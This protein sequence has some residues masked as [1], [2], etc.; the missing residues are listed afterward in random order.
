MPGN[1]LREAILC[2]HG[3][4]KKTQP[5]SPGVL[6]NLGATK[7]KKKKRCRWVSGSLSE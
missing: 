4:E 7:V 2:G 6:V 1:S 5:V 3:T